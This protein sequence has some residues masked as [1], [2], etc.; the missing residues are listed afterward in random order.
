[1]EFYYGKR[2]NNGR[3]SK[4]DPDSHTVGGK[5]KGFI[6][7]KCFN[8]NHYLPILAGVSAIIMLLSGSLYIQ[9][10]FQMENYPL[11]LSIFYLIAGYGIYQISTIM[12]KY[13][14]G[15]INSMVVDDG[16]KQLIKEKKRC[17]IK[18]AVADQLHLVFHALWQQSDFD[19]TLD[20][21]V[22]S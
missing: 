11:A 8:R 17:P 2:T 6:C 15:E 16:S 14:K 19:C 12:K 20:I 22:A 4:V 1:L 21:N 9:Y 5:Y 7:H 13:K 18:G 10:T 3:T